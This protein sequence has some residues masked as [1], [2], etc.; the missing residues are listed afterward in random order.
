MLIW[1][2]LRLH[3]IS[4]LLIP[5]TFYKVNLFILILNWGNEDLRLTCSGLCRLR[6]ETE[7]KSRDFW[8]SNPGYQPKETPVTCLRFTMNILLFS[9]SEQNVA[10]RVCKPLCSSLLFKAPDSTLADSAVSSGCFLGPPFLADVLNA[11]ILLAFEKRNQIT[12]LN[13]ED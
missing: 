8:F 1:Q 3:I 11:W 13:Q 6:V 5:K 2:K 12:W 9:S 10:F 7:F 4:S